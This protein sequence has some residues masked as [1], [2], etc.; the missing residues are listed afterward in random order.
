M[1]KIHPAAARTWLFTVAKNIL[2]EHFR[3]TENNRSVSLENHDIVSDESILYNPPD[4]DIK[5][6][7]DEV[8][9]TLSPF[10]LKLY[11]YIKVLH[12]T[13]SETASRLGLTARQV[14]YKSLNITK[15]IQYHLLKM[16]L[17]DISEF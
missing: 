5:I 6:I 14:R 17:K 7:A 15:H 11:V 3:S 13:E 8:Q 9:K 2:N 10:D 1:Q 12:L 4:Y 16:G